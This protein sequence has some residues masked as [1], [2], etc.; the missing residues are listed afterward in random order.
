MNNKYP[1]STGLY[2]DMVEGII[3]TFTDSELV[4]VLT[5]NFDHYKAALE[6]RHCRI[7]CYDNYSDYVGGMEFGIYPD[8]PLDLLD[9]RHYILS[10]LDGDEKTEVIEM[11]RFHK[12]F[13]GFMEKYLTEFHYANTLTNFG[14]YKYTQEVVSL[15]RENK[16]KPMNL[17]HFHPSI[18]RKI[19]WFLYGGDLSRSVL[20]T[21]RYIQDQYI[22]D[23]SVVEAITLTKNHY[24]SCVKEEYREVLLGI[25]D[26]I[27]QKLWNTNIWEGVDTDIN[28]R[29]ILL[30][31]GK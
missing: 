10:N 11:I 21:I 14:H 27:N 20:D 15:M 5:G 28:I 1:L 17:Y 9:L 7:N 26:T 31:V 30:Y 12:D 4:D 6:H 29:N 22:R 25:T 18:R 13:Y 8:L 16:G 24:I 23:R 19:A 3:N 2:R